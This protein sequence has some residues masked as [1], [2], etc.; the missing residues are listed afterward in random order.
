MHC[1]VCSKA[2]LTGQLCSKSVH[3]YSD[4]YVVDAKDTFALRAGSAQRPVQEQ[5][6]EIYCKDSWSRK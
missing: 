2:G 4:N 6:L 5:C 1:P 3:E